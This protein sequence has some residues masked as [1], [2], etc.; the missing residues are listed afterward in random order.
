MELEVRAH[1]H[2]S[3]IKPWDSRDAYPRNLASAVAS[4]LPR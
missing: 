4:L 2:R 3:L 1:R